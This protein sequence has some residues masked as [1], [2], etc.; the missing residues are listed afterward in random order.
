MCT[1]MS[2]KVFK[3]LGFEVSDDVIH[4]ITTCKPWAVEQF[5]LMLREKVELCVSMPA[6]S[7]PLSLPNSATGERFEHGDHSLVYVSGNNILVSCT[8]TVF[9]SS[10]CVCLH[11]CV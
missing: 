7:L 8:C 1:L 6:Q 9:V 2:R 10:V 5:L 4:N 3:K 11:P